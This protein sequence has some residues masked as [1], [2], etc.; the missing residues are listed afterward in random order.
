MRSNDDDDGNGYG[1]GNGSDEQLQVKDAAVVAAAFDDNY[2]GGTPPHP[3]THSSLSVNLPPIFPSTCPLSPSLS[4]GIPSREMDK[5]RVKRER[6]RESFFI[7]SFS[8]V[9][10]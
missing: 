7:G 1:Y 10:R 8:R 5:V 4:L 6:E 2:D 3:P 9:V